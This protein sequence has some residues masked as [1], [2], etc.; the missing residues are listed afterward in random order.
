MEKLVLLQKPIIFEYDAQSVHYGKRQSILTSVLIIHACAL[1]GHES[2]KKEALK[3]AFTREDHNP[4]EFSYTY[5][6]KAFMSVNEIKRIDIQE[7]KLG[8]VARLAF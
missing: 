5:Q 6:L 4:V 1:M 3:I 7:P 2:D 8:C